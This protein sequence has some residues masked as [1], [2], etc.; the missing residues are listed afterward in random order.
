MKKIFFFIVLFYSFNSY[1]FNRKSSNCCDTININYLLKDLAV[2]FQPLVVDINISISKNKR[3]KSFLENNNYN[4]LSNCS[5]YENFVVIVLLK[6]YKYHL[7]NSHQ[8]YDLL[9]MKSGISFNIIEYFQELSGYKGD[10]E[11]L[12]SGVIMDY[13]LKNKSRLN[14]SLINKVFKEIKLI[15]KNLIMRIKS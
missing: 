1:S 6:Q 12:S 15:E 10:L 9:S 5:E 8:S 3:I 2:K 14:N 13:V 4:C 11:M 7:K